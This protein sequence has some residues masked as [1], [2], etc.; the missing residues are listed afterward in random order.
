MHESTLSYY[1]APGPM[2]DPG[3][4]AAR[5]DALPTAVPALV[6]E[7]I[8]EYTQRQP[9]HPRRDALGFDLVLKWKS[10]CHLSALFVNSPFTILPCTFKYIKP[11]N[12]LSLTC[13]GPSACASGPVAGRQTIY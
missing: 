2:T 10:R 3:E 7:T 8:T 1:A 4:H 11:E 9:P 5:F 12:A 13:V 6:E